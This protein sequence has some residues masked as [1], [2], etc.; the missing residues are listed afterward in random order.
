MCWRVLACGALL[1]GACGPIEY[2]A[3]VP[4][5]AAGL[6]GEAK[7]VHGEK[8]A[9]YEMTAANEYLH[10]SRELAGFARFHSSVEFAR[11]ATRL[12]QEAKKI[13]Q[14]KA[15]MPDQQGDETPAAA[16]VSVTPVPDPAPRNV[17]VHEVST[18]HTDKADPKK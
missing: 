16:P 4:L 6:V 7:H 18:V 9:P 10:K 15:A 13:S 11:K 1:L 14:D 3:N 5:E 17:D 12:A 8:Y 2:I